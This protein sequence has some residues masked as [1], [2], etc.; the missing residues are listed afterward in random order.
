MARYDGLAEWYDAHVNG[1]ETDAGALA[2]EILGSLLG[3]GQGRRCVDLGCGGGVRIPALVG[4]GWSVVGVDVSVDQLRVARGRVG[5]VAELVHGDAAT[6]PFEDGSFDAVASAF[7]HTDVDDVAALFREAARIVRPQGRLAYVGS[8]P[9]FVG[10]FSER[11]GARRILHP[12]Y[13][14][15]RWHDDGPG[16]GEG[17]RRRVGVRHVPLSELLTAIATAGFTL[18]RVVE[19]GRDDPPGLLALSGWRGAAAPR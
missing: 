7:I 3:P 13:R 10:P 17:V 19:A 5:D 6:L 11:E 9:C 4:L 8:H 2:T 18:E 16:I 12:G 15:A 14:E 1:P